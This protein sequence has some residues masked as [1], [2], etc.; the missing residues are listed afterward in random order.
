[1]FECTL[2]IFCF[3]GQIQTLNMLFQLPAFRSALRTC[4]FLSFWIPALSPLAYSHAELSYS[5]YLGSPDTVSSAKFKSIDFQP[6]EDLDIGFYFGN[7]WI[8]CQVTNTGP[9]NT[10]ILYTYDCF[11][12]EYHFYEISGDSLS[13]L[14]QASHHSGQSDDRYFNFRNPNFRIDLKQGETKN[15]LI[16]INSD[17]R[18]VFATPAIVTLNEFIA[19]MRHTTIFNVGFFGL[20]GFFF[21]LNLLLAAILKRTIFLL[22]GISIFCNTFFMLGFDGSLYNIGLDNFVVDHLIF[23][24]I[25]LWVFTFLIFTSIFLGIKAHSPKFY[26]V[27]KMY[28]LIVMLGLT[29]YQLLFWNSSI[30][31]LH[32]LE[33]I[34]GYS[35]I[36]VLVAGLIIAPKT[37]RKEKMSYLAVLSVFSVLIILALSSSHKSNHLISPS[38]LYKIGSLIEFIGFTFIMILY[39]GRRLKEGTESLQ[40]LEEDKIKKELEIESTNQKLVKL[41][42]EIK[43]LLAKNEEGASTSTFEVTNLPAIFELMKANISQEEGWLQFQESFLQLDPSFLSSLVQ[44]TPDLSKS[45]I[46]LLVLLKIGYSQ[47]EIAQLLAISP[48]SVKKARQ[49][50]RKKLGLTTEV[51]IGEYLSSL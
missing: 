33:N 30:T 4:L 45:E 18:I 32:Q 14:P 29:S 11:Q 27:S 1:M 9:A 26:S 16:H 40:E 5:S 6:I 43:E 28:V 22:Y 34:I 31:L 13:P 35:W 2:N 48:G 15:F 20:V 49:R 10:F 7:I 39:F 37:R 19:S 8:K 50:T 21:L 51:T 46:R 47:K 38:N 25:R 12:R 23:I 44:R 24:S 3:A 42:N 41:E 36:V 17:G